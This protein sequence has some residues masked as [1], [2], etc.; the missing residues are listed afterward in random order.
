MTA[1][2]PEAYCDEA[3]ALAQAVRDLM[4]DMRFKQ[5]ILENYIEE[6][7]RAI[8]SDFDN[9]PEQIDALKAVTHLKRWL[10]QAIDEGYKIKEELSQ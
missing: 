3:I 6:T 7:T 2:T 4:N 9:T 5:V 1:T 10:D 8:G